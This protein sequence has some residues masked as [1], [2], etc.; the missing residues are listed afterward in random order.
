MSDPKLSQ[1]N[2]RDTYSKSKYKYDKDFF[3][4]ISAKKTPSQMV[5]K[6]LSK[7]DLY[8]FELPTQREVDEVGCYGIHLGD[9][10]Q[11]IFL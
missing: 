10:I 2:R 4:K 9:F 11:N 6:Y 1:L 3:V 7:K 8:P 5:S